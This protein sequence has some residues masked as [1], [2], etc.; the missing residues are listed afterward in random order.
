M[1]TLMEIIPPTSQA[2]SS[3]SFS[4]IA[5]SSTSR[6]RNGETI[7]SPARDDDQP[8][9]GGQPRP[10]RAEQRDDAAA[11][12]AARR[13]RRL[14]RG[15]QAATGFVAGSSA[16]SS[17]SPMLITG[18]K[19]I[20]LAHVG[21]DVVQVAA[22]ALGQDDLGDAGRVGGEHLLLEAADREHPALQRDLA[23]HARQCA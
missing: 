21:R 14:A 10:V 4:G 8:E 15:A 23:G 5:T 12:A 17:T 1:A 7:P 2:S 13:R 3:R 9:D 16:A 20:A 22:V 18:W 6:S 11:V 19:V